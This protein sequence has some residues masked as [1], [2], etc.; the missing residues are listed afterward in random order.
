M[1]VSADSRGRVS[2]AGSRLP[3]ETMRVTDLG[4]GLSQNPGRW[5]TP[6]PAH[7]PGKVTADLA[8]PSL[9][10]AENLTRLGST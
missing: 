1:A 5:W 9:S 2:Q 3:W 7:D 6:R 4:R 8:A 10:A